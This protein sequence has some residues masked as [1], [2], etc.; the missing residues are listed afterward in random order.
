[1]LLAGQDGLN[2]DVQSYTVGDLMP[3]AFRSFEIKSDNPGSVDPDNKP[4]K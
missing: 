3:L 4:E 2:G 1:M